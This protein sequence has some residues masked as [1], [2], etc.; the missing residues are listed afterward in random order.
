MDK[1]FNFLGYVIHC[2]I[3]DL[4]FLSQ[5]IVLNIYRNQPYRRLPFQ[6]YPRKTKIIIWIIINLI[7][8][9]SLMVLDLL[10]ITMV[11]VVI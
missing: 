6:Q 5:W 8:L 2:L 7:F 1:T 11:I 10:Y 9:I 4:Y 3:V